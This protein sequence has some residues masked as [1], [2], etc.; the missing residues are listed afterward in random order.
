V[1]HGNGDLRTLLNRSG[2]A[3]LDGEG[4][5]GGIELPS[6]ALPVRS[7]GTTA[8]ELAVRHGTPVIVADRTLVAGL[9]DEVA[10]DLPGRGRALAETVAQRSWRA[11]ERVAPEPEQ[12]WKWV[13]WIW[14][15]WYVALRAEAAVPGTG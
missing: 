6:G 2:V 11:L 9:V 3:V 15:H 10:E 8:T 13:T 1:A 4:D 12:V 14:L 5:S 7:A